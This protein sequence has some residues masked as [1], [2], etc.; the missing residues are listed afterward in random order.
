[1]PGSLGE[2]RGGG[3]GRNGSRAGPRYL[4][5]CVVGLG[6]TL[7]KVS[8]LLALP[9]PSHRA[10]VLQGARDGRCRGQDVVHRLGC[11]LGEHGGHQMRRG[12]LS[13]HDRV[14][15]HPHKP[16]VPRIHALLCCSWGPAKLPPPRPGGCKPPEGT[17][18]MSS[19]PTPLLLTT[20]PGTLPAGGC[21]RCSP[22]S[23]HGLLPPAPCQLQGRPWRKPG[24]P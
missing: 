3:W 14:G 4:S 9:Q 8:R 22:S 10:L 15:A 7:P 13:T 21:H 24:F 19:G 2:G 12:G 6:H 23:A 16:C 18:L 17:L 20:T 1:M 5:N 11:G